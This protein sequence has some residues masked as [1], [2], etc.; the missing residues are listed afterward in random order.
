MRWSLELSKF[1]IKFKA[2]KALK[3]QM[4]VDFVVEMTSSVGN[5]KNNHLDHLR[6]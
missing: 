3:A 5:E 1:D 6:R 4:L 2:R